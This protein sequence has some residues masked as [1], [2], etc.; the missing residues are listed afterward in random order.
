M[1]VDP[2][3]AVAR[4][5]HTALT[6]ARAEAVERMT[7]PQRDQYNAAVTATAE[8]LA[9]LQDAKA[10]G[11]R[12]P[13]SDVWAVAAP[14][15][16]ADI[17]IA[18]KDIGLL[19]WQRS[20]DGVATALS[21]LNILLLMTAAELAAVEAQ[22]GYYGDRKVEVARGDAVHAAVVINDLLRG[23]T[24]LQTD[25][26]KTAV[27]AMK[28]AQQKAAQPQGATTNIDKET[29]ATKSMHG[30]IGLDE[31]LEVEFC[32]EHRLAD[33]AQRVLGS[34]DPETYAGNQTKSSNAGSTGKLNFNTTVGYARLIIGGGAFKSKTTRKI[35]ARWER[36]S[37]TLIGMENGVVKV[38]WYLRG[39]EALDML[40]AFPDDQSF[41]PRLYL[42]MVSNHAFTNAIN[43]PWWRFDVGGDRKA[44][45]DVPAATAESERTRLRQAICEFTT[46]DF[47]AHKPLDFWNRDLTQIPLD[48][49]KKEQQA[50]DR[51]EELLAPNGARLVRDPADNY[52]ATDWHVITQANNDTRIQNKRVSPGKTACYDIFSMSG[53]RG[54]PYDLMVDFDSLDVFDPRTDIMY[55]LPA[56]VP[57][58]DGEVPYL[59]ATELSKGTVRL[60]ANWKACHAPYRCDL[61]T[62]EG[63]L[64]Y[65][66]LQDKRGV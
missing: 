64:K 18:G 9:R 6:A 53:N 37:L 63:V 49:H 61:R 48:S 56:R 47:A 17:R 11:E 14:N 3:I 62:E 59:S 66:R 25:A 16:L 13:M 1:P 10:R 41:H 45:G 31:V 27:N 65:L 21:V 40:A 23:S 46:G 58:T 35:V 4:A 20:H 22:R 57:S 30:L 60:S 19:E 7:S 42:K 15:R 50:L 29:A 38:V 5:T 52:G 34:A 54:K 24:Q 12:W 39:Q 32:I 36:M 44:S 33:E 26:E 28:S 51:I 55:S 2:R 43:N 8:P